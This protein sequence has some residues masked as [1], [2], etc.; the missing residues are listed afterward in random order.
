[1]NYDGMTGDVLELFVEAS[2]LQYVGRDRASPAAREWLIAD[3]KR[4]TI[5][6]CVVRWRERNPSAR[7]EQQRREAEQKR[8]KRA[9]ERLRRLV[10]GDLPPARGLGKQWQEAAKLLGIE[11]PGRAA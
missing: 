2:R 8:A 7:L 3:R 6:S 1:M 11:L 4:E 5:V 9:Q 10:A